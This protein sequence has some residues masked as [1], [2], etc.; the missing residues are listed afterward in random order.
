MTPIEIKNLKVGEILRDSKI[1]GLHVRA[2][3]SKKVFYLYYRTKSGIER[4]PKIGD[5][6]IFSINEARLIS[7]TLLIRVASGEDPAL[8]NRNLRASPTVHEAF[9]EMLKNYWTKHSSKRWAKEVEGLYNRRIKRPFGSHKL[10]EITPQGVEKWHGNLKPTPI[11]ANRALA[12]LSQLY[13]RQNK[14]GLKDFN[15]NPCLLAKPFKEASRSRYATTKELTHIIRILRT[16]LGEHENE[17]KQEAAFILL[18][19]YTGSRPSYLE[20]ATIKDFNPE[21]SLLTLEGK[22]GVE[23]VVIPRSIIRYLEIGVGTK[24]HKVKNLWEKI[25][26][27]V[28]CKDLWMRDLR[29]TFA[30]IGLSSGE[31]MSQISETLNHKSQQTTKI[32]AKLFDEQKEKMVNEIAMR[33][34]QLI[35]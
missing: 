13:S 28:G 20:R 30:T 15:S 34:D 22:E 3:K 9:E 1:K 32:Y 23:S 5:V 7:K 10:N 6:D 35:I 2:F 26:E 19:I 29:R 12:I 31:S 11:D 14:L 16:H 4:R 8:T 18:L 21:T 27:E 17:W 25:R 33:I 24:L